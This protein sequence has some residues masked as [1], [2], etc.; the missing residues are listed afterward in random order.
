MYSIETTYHDGQGNEKTLVAYDDAVLDQRLKVVDPVLE[1]EDNSA[2]SLEFTVYPTNQAYGEVEDSTTDPLSLMT[3]TVRVF[4]V[5]PIAP[6]GQEYPQLTYEREEIFEGRPLSIEKD[7]YNGKK[8]YCEGAFCYLND[9]DQQA[10]EFTAETIQ[11]DFTFPN[12][13]STRGGNLELI[14]FIK[15][16]LTRYND[17]AALNRIFDIDGTYVYP[18]RIPLGYNFKGCLADKAA[19]EAVQNPTEK[20]IYQT[21][22]GLTGYAT[23]GY[24]AEVSDL[25]DIASPQSNDLCYVTA[26]ESYYLYDGITWDKTHVMDYIGE[27]YVYTTDPES[28]SANPRKKWSDVTTQIHITCGIS[29]STGGE[30]TKQTISSLVENFGGHIKVRTVNGKRCIYYTV[31]TYPEDEFIGATG[32]KI[33]QSVDFGKN[34]IDLT[35]TRDGSEFFT[36]L[37]PIGAEISNDHPETIESMCENVIEHG[38]LLVGEHMTDLVLDNLVQPYDAT[39]QISYSSLGRDTAPHQ[40]PRRTL[41]KNGLEPGYT[42]YLFTTSYNQDTGDGTSLIQSN[43]YMY[44]FYDSGPNRPNVEGTLAGGIAHPYYVSPLISGETY[45]A[46]AEA[47]YKNDR[48]L[49][50]KQLPVSDTVTELVGEQFTIPEKGSGDGYSLYFSCATLY[51]RAYDSQ[52]HCIEMPNE[53]PYGY[54]DDHTLAYPKLYRAPYPNKDTSKLKVREVDPHYIWWAGCTKYGGVQRQDIDPHKLSVANDKYGT[55]DYDFYIEQG[56]YIRV[57]DY[58]NVGR[59]SWHKMWDDWQLDGSKWKQTNNAN[60]VFPTGMT[61]HHI[62]RVL[63]EPGKTYYLN[64]RVTNPGYPESTAG[65]VDTQGELPNDAPLHSI[66]FVNENNRYAGKTSNTEPYYT[67][68][69][70]GVG[71]TQDYSHGDDSGM[72][73]KRK[74]DD[75]IAYAVV[76]RRPVYISENG[77]HEISSSWKWQIIEKGLADRSQCATVYNMHEIKIP[78][79]IPP[80]SVAKPG[81][82]INF[83]DSEGNVTVSSGDQICHLELWFACDECYINGNGEYNREQT[84]LIGYVPQVFVE[85]ESAFGNEGGLNYKNHVTVKPLQPAGVN[86]SNWPEEYL[87]NKELYDKYGPIVKVSQYDNAYTPSQLMS[88]AK[89]EIERMKGEESF[90]V[91]AVDMKSCGLE[92]CDRLRLMQRIKINDTP[93]GISSSIVLSKMSLDLMDLSK[94]S[95]TLGYEAN[96]GISAQ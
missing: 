6:S 78:D 2:G 63:V 39:Q 46:D 14:D 91:S 47:V 20:D 64:T 82:V 8:F 28:T 74:Y 48:L 30:S 65:K 80:E 52:G 10:E 34:L 55:N 1:L 27:Y 53:I 57:L 12:K 67:F 44:F 58:S 66:Y 71:E 3:A 95:Y 19:I 75:V 36:V 37:L 56:T 96:R 13:K 79:S 89:N 87:V 51:A 60:W 85:D 15:A 83:Y 18:V 49:A 92:D 5:P 90:E 62:A 43:N 32:D 22:T 40:S 54:W 7:F 4:M 69:D 93:H 59:S 11:N 72:M 61:G 88:Y 70:W 45:A 73:K 50:M 17:R 21:M 38:D 24:V 86:G 76:V 41:A 23:R 16:V 68:P 77:N 35:K 81:E 42:Y 29:R 26:E 94:N 33:A 25:D 84:E 31:K 9:I